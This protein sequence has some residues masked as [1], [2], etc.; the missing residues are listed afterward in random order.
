VVTNVFKVPVSLPKTKRANDGP[1]P[2]PSKKAQALS[3]V[4]FIAIVETLNGVLESKSTA[5]DIVA[6][7]KYTANN[8]EEC[9][10][11]INMALKSVG[12]GSGDDLVS[13][14]NNRLCHVPSFFSGGEDLIYLRGRDI[15]YA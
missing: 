3:Q 2:S 10:G 15:P 7:R 6:T 12:S 4:G 5:K 9:A 8:L 1:D 13:V 14:D 11:F